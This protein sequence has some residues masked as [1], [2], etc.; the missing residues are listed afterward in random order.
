MR[1]VV[2][3]C[4]VALGFAASVAAQDT[5][6][7]TKTTVEGDDA[8]ATVVS[9][10]L[11]GGPATFTLISNSAPLTARERSAEPGAVGTSG[12]V[13]A[14]SLSARDGVDLK[15][16]IGQRVEITG[17]E[18]AAGD[19]DDDAEVAVKEETKIERDDAPDDKITSRTEA[20]VARGP[21]PKLAVTSVKML[22]ST[23]T[24]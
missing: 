20:K 1:H 22:S 7:T 5:K 9:G 10:C 4:L 23:C 16:H 15:T 24:P 14:Y 6:I 12:A 17:V 21:A 18:I 13:S 8:K 19:K 11:M 3:T 2:P